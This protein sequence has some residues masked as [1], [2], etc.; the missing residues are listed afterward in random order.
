L[1]IQRADAQTGAAHDA[2][3]ASGTA[4]AAYFASFADPDLARRLARATLARVSTHLGFGAVREY[5][6]GHAGAGDVDSGPVVLGVS[7]S[8]TGFALAAARLADDADAFTALYRTTD[9]FGLP[10]QVDDRRAFA[11]GGPIGNALLLALL[12]VAR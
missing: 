10:I 6:D 11:V 8:A 3:R 9:L 7:V 1:L 4:L 12:T 2:P 5:A